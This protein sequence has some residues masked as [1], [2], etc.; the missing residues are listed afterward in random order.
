MP[1]CGEAFVRE[2]R[3]TLHAAPSRSP[4]RFGRRP[5]GL[6]FGSAPRR[7]RGGGTVPCSPAGGLRGARDPFVRRASRRV[8]AP[9]ASGRCLRGSQ[10]RAGAAAT[11]AGVCASSRVAGRHAPRSISVH[12]TGATAAASRARSAGGADATPVR[13][14]SPAVPHAARLAFRDAARPPADEESRLAQAGRARSQPRHG[15]PLT[16]RGRPRGAVRRNSRR[17]RN[18]GIERVRIEA[19]RRRRARAGQ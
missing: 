7:V 11:P 15:R 9:R 8:R 3:N 4:A 19:V 2:L 16:R 18:T 1:A 13:A 12:T 14:H 17:H 5:R 10:A 6:R